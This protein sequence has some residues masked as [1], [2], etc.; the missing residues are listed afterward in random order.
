LI[1]RIKYIIIFLFILG[2]GLRSDLI[3]QDPIFTQFYNAPLQINPAFAGNTFAPKVHIN[4]RIEWPSI[5]LAYTTY[6]LSVDRFFKE[7]NFG[8]GLLFMMD[9]SG[10][11]IYKR[12]R[13]EG[14]F[15]YRLKVVK[16]K[17]LKMGL[18]IAYGQNSLDWQKLVFGDQID[19]ISGYVLPDGTKLTSN[20][21]KP[22]NLTVNYVD[23]SAGIL[24][25]SKELFF[26]VAVKHANTPIDYYNK[27]K[28][29]VN[30]G[31]PVRFT[32]QIGAEIDLFPSYSKINSFYSP[33]LLFVS[34]SGLNQ[35][36]LNNYFDLGSVF[37]N[38]GYRYN[39]VNSDALLLSV[40]V[41]KQMFKIAY[42]FDYTVSSLSIGSGGSHEIGITINFDESTL[43][44]K[45]YRYSDCF[46]MFR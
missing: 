41:N 31:L 8:A 40:G 19:P 3:S 38:L 7:N 2:T 22:D 23:L 20:E 5:G 14:V 26:G 13:A 30:K 6:S 29:N 33:S 15:A 24:Y 18:S 45:P 27:S 10:S 12:F 1:F 9:N 42:S 46:D 4:S 16:Q 39:I 17:Y 25:Y 34:Q 32:A 36:V 11:G 44:E 28:S 37:A 21:Q 35:L 43:F